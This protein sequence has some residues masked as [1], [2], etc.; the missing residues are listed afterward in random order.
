MNLDSIVSEFTH[1]LTSFLNVAQD[2]IWKEDHPLAFNMTFSI[3]L[4]LLPVKLS[5]ETT[6]CGIKNSA[7]PVE[8]AGDEGS[9]S[10]AFSICSLPLKST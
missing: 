2:K 8:E 6:G 9:S 3:S 5:L 10:K 1:L 4:G 7:L